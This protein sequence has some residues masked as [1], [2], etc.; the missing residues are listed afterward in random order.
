MVSEQP[1]PTLCALVTTKTGEAP[2]VIPLP[3][4]LPLYG[5]GLAV[6]GFLGWR[7]KRRAAA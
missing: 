6:M 3:A 1:F 5:T 7:R 2:A 4:A